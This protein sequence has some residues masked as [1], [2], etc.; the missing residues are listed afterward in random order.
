MGE[1][2]VE[3][4]ISYV[5]KYRDSIPSGVG[6]M[7]LLVRGLFRGT[8]DMIVGLVSVRWDSST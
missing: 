7:V 5:P 8:N 3:S 6:E 1:K 2:R 4:G